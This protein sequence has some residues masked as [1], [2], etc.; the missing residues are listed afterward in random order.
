LKDHLHTASQAF[1]SLSIKRCNIL[2]FVPDVA[3]S[4][5]SQPGNEPA[6]GGLPRTGLP[7]QAKR[8]TFGDGKADAINR[9]DLTPIK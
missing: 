5:L 9:F 4:W 7:N 3:S 6:R 2:A 1:E 8:G